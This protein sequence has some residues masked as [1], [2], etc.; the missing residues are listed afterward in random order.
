MN[1]LENIYK[2]DKT[3][4]INELNKINKLKKEFSEKWINFILAN[5]HNVNYIEFII[6]Y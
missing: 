6:K 4:N 2:F 5:K 3:K 1:K